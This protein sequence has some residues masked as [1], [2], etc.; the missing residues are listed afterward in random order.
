MCLLSSSALAIGQQLPVN[1]DAVLM[2]HAT[3]VYLRKNLVKLIDD[4][5]SL[6]V[7]PVQLKI[8]RWNTN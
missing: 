3:R 2:H 7:L 6:V 8:G 4:I 1:V 5:V